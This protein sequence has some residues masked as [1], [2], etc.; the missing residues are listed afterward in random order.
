MAVGS[1]LIRVDNLQVHFERQDGGRLVRAVD[2]ASFSLKRGEILALV[3][4]SGCGKSAVGRALLLLERPTSGRIFFEGKSLTSWRNRLWDKAHRQI[5]M[6]FRDPYLTFSPRL[7]VEQ[8]VREVLAATGFERGAPRDQKIR[9]LLELVGLNLYLSIRYPWELSGGNRQRLAIARALAANPALLVCDQVG[10]MLDPAVRSSIADLLVGL[11]EQMGMALLLIANRL[12]EVGGSDR[13]AIMVQ[14]RIV[15]MGH[16]ADVI[17]QPLHPF[18]Q[19]LLQ[20]AGYWGEPQPALPDVPQGCRYAP[21]CPLAA[22]K[23]RQ[24]YP[25]FETLLPVHTVACHL[26]TVPELES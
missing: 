5:Q 13:L 22:D 4:A 21:F 12:A 2:G 17:A 24:V 14:G 26:A 8:T 1:E 6:I 7:T 10:D 15:E 3:G 9:E 18:T 25:S 11:R 19:A 20:N 16:T 23:C